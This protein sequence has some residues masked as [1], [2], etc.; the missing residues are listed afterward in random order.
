MKE[1]LSQLHNPNDSKAENSPI[2]EESYLTSLGTTILDGIQVVIENVHVRYEHI[3][4]ETSI[5]LTI[6]EVSILSSDEKFQS[7]QFDEREHDLFY[8]LASIRSASLYFNV[9]DPPLSFGNYEEMKEKMS[10]MIANND[11]PVLGR[12]YILFPTTLLSKFQVRKDRKPSTEGERDREEE[13]VKNAKFSAQLEMENIRL[14]LSQVQ[15]KN[16]MDVVDYLIALT[17]QLKHRQIRPTVSPLK[18]PKSWWIY[19]CTNFFFKKL[20]FF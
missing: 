16:L 6:R 9:K 17:A 15:F 18:D 13:R 5:G 2:N 3:Y 1:I 12:N 10:P 14:S 4:S 20:K 8:K 11:E 7:C 19:S